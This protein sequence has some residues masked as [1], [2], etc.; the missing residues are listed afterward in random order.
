MGEQ[1]FQQVISLGPNCRAKHHIQ[2]IF[3]KR[4]SPRGVFDW[5]VTPEE[6]FI[7]YLGRD[8]RGIFERSDLI[9]QEGKVVNKRLGTK[10][11]H[12]FPD[13]ASEVEVD[14]FFSTAKQVHD[15]AAAVTRR[16][17]ENNLTTLFVVGLPVS[18]ALFD[19]FEQ[20]VRRKSPRKRFKILAAPEGD[21]LT[22]PMNEGWI[23]DHEVWTRHLTQFEISPPLSVRAGYQI[24]RLRKNLRYL[25]PFRERLKVD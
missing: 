11:P 1:V 10:H 5:Q 17:I 8:F 2:R 15:Q 19:E 6:A 13:K 20:H 4:I 21:D 14:R 25:A 22:D 23:G 7:E 24:Y 9:I 18:D 16:A 12:E 3:G